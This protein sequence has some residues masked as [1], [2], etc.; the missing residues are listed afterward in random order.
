MLTH[1]VNV[2]PPGLLVYCKI[3]NKHLSPFSSFQRNE[4]ETIFAQDIAKNVPPFGLSGKVFI[5]WEHLLGLL[6]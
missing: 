1:I 6:Q 2:V 5:G 4:N 3:P